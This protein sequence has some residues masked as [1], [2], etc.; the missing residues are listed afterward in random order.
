VRSFRRAKLCPSEAAFLPAWITGISWSDHWSFWREGY[1][2]VMVT[3]T[4]LFRYRWYH[5]PD[6]TPEKLNYD[7]FTLV[8]EGLKN[9]VADLAGAHPAR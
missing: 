1:P 2:A 4:A 8:V 7:R 3:D 5:T 6:D 9:V